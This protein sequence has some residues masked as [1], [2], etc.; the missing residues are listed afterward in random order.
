MSEQSSHDIPNSAYDSP[1]THRVGEVDEEIFQDVMGTIEGL[2]ENPPEGSTVGNGWYSRTLTLPSQ[3]GSLLTLSHYLPEGREK[4]TADLLPQYDRHDIDLGTA[5]LIGS[6]AFIEE[7]GPESRKV[8]FSGQ[9][10]LFIGDRILGLVSSRADQ[11]FDLVLRDGESCF[12]FASSLGLGEEWTR[13]VL[14]A[15]ALKGRRYQEIV[16]DFDN[17]MAERLADTLISYEEES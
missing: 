12:S 16:A 1:E 5:R 6:V 10:D 2:I 7:H 17:G 13:T 9:I 3:P 14:D 4:N 15:F 8:T 11:L